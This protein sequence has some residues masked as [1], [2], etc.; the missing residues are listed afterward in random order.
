MDE[1]PFQHECGYNLMGGEP[2][3]V[4]KSHWMSPLKRTS[5]ICMCTPLNLYLFSFDSYYQT[6]PNA[7]KN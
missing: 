4:I 2:R 5:L 1:C 3:G 7:R 6:K